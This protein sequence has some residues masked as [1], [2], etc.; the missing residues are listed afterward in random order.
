MNQHN[1]LPIKA[2]LYVGGGGGVGEG[3]R[4]LYGGVFC[5][6]GDALGKGV[7]RWQDGEE[8]GWLLLKE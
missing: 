1:V 5:R 6:G 8:E 4:Q 3:D 7:G 2:G